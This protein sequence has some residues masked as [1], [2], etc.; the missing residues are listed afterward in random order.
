MLCF[1]QRII[2]GILGSLEVGAPDFDDV[3]ELYDNLGPLLHQIAGRGSSEEEI[4]AIC[5]DLFEMVGY[6]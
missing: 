2:G 3:E 6:V 4:R 5:D 1:P